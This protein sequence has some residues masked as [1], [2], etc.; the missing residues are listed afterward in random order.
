MSAD[1]RICIGAFAGA[2]GVRGDAKI[3]T[4]TE[5]PASVAAYGPVETEDGARR[6]SLKIIRVLKPGLVL[7]RAPEIESREDAAALSGKRLFIDRARLPQAEEDEFYLDDLIGLHAF[8]ETGA[9]LGEVCAVYDFGAG[10][11]IELENVP[12]RKGKVMIPFLRKTVP[13]V[14]LAAG[15]ITIA[16]DALEETEASEKDGPSLSDETGEIVSDDIVVDLDAM[17]EEDS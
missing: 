4:F 12:G 13:A 8:D 5:D 3:K 15:R 1:K 9:E 6:F 10:D 11:I 7:A 16:A 14:D 17:R 2:H